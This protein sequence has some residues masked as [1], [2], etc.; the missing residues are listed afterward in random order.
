MIV[1]FIDLLLPALSKPVAAPHRL[2]NAS[3]SSRVM[4][5]E[6]ETRRSEGGKTRGRTRTREQS[7][8]LVFRLFY[9][10]CSNLNI[11]IDLSV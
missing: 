6:M 3:Q 4:K 10:I 11:D 5:P 7:R 1:P 2:S 8:Y 9:F